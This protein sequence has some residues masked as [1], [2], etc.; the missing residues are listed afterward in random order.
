MNAKNGVK[1]ISARRMNR[2][3][4]I[5]DGSIHQKAG[6]LCRKC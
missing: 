1:G 2:V 6:Y 5:I 4:C 3:M